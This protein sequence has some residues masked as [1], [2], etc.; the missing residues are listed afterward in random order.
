MALSLIFA[1]PAG[2]FEG[3]YQIYADLLTSKNS[4]QIKVA[5][6]SIFN[7]KIHDP[8]LTDLVAEVFA[9]IIDKQ[10]SID[11]DTTA[12]VA[13]AI[14]VS[15]SKRYTPLLTAAKTSGVSSKIKKYIS[16]SLDKLTQS[17]DGAYVKGSVDLAQV[18]A[19]IAKQQKEQDRVIAPEKFKQVSIGDTLDQ[20]ITKLG[21]PTEYDITFGSRRQRWVG[22]IHYSMLGF[23]FGDQGAF[24]L[25]YVAKSTNWVV[26]SI[27]AGAR[28]AGGLA[29]HPMMSPSANMMRAY[30]KT[31]VKQASA[32]ELDRDIAAERLY[33]DLHNE[34]FIDTL[35]WACRLLGLSGTDRYRSALQ[36]VSNT[37]KFSKLRK[38]AQNNLKQLPSGLSAQYEQGGVLNIKAD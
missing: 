37:T 2:A 7:K 32:T 26:K 20:V 17:A 35:S 34:E 30:I 5:A 24:N 23:T 29:D 13:K 11:E 21:M 3:E 8:A 22:T 36:Y 16:K 9:Q 18:V 28:F 33:T 31:L 12:W 19:T 4:A 27:K 6:K 25:H 14:G 1:K 10:F 15:K 38:Y